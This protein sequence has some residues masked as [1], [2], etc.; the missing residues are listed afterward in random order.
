MALCVV[1]IDKLHCIYQEEGFSCYEKYVDDMLAPHGK[2][3]LNTLLQ[4]E[5]ITKEL[6]VSTSSL[7]ALHCFI[8]ITSLNSSMSLIL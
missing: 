6:A 5:D 8:F 7:I 4:R 3:R 2:E 1:L